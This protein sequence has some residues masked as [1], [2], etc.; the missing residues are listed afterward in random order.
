MN[1]MF[2]I[3]VALVVI[4]L[5]MTWTNFS[6]E[7]KVPQKSESSVAKEKVLQVVGRTTMTFDGIGATTGF[8]VKD[9]ENL[10]IVHYD[11]GSHFANPLF[12][13]KYLIAMKFAE[14]KPEVYDSMSVEATN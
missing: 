13:P 1:K 4:A 2:I 14:D 3:A 7:A 8:L 9:G 12:Q 5:N 6:N 10:R 11:Q